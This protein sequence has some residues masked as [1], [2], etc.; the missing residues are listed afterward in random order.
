MKSNR[1]RSEKHSNLEEQRAEY[2]SKMEI[3][4]EIR[5]EKELREKQTAMV[6][7]MKQK[8]HGNEIR[9]QANQFKS[10]KDVER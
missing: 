3:I 1:I 10:T 4:E 5:R 8:K 7:E 2:Q 6:N 9:D